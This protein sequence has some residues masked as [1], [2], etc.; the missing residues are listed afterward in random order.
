MTFQQS[1]QVVFDAFR[2]RKQ[3]VD[4]LHSRAAEIWV[5]HELHSTSLVD[6]LVSVQPMPLPRG[7]VFHLDFVITEKGARLDT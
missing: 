5:A 4:D 6:Q 1:K 2:R 3:H 7:L